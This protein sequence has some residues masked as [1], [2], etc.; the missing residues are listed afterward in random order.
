MI[1]TSQVPV[2][3]W[4]EQIGGATVADGIL[5]GLVHN[6]DRIE[7]KGES[8]RK[9]KGSRQS[10]NR[11]ARDVAGAE[12]G[13]GAGAPVPHPFFRGGRSA[14]LRSE[15]AERRFFLTKS[16]ASPESNKPASLRSDGD[17]RG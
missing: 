2:A 13:T 10:A 1:L 7:L 5:D 3:N 15:R 14:S 11:R 8:M 9:N 12:R 6:P 16:I 17:R 4:H